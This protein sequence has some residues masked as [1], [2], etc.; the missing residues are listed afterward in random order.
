MILELK[1]EQ[2]KVLDRAVQSGMSPEEVL[3]QAFAVIDQQYG[4]EDWMLADK[5]AIAAQIEVGFAQAERGELI[6]AEQAIQIL[7]ER[8]ETAYSLRNAP[9]YQFTPQA[10][11]DL[12]DIWDYIAEDNVKAA[13]RVESAILS[14]CNGLAAHPLIGS[15]R[16]EIT[17]LPVRYWTVTRFPNFIVVYRPNTKPLQIVK[18]VHGKKEY[19]GSA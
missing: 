11:N 8:G 16:S 5:E 17:P 7:Q 6:D 12:S 13:N 14:A 3:D 2:Q 15:K 10:L 19:P 4:S 9:S 18:V 1:P